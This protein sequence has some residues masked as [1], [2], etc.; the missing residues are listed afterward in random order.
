MDFDLYFYTLGI[1][2]LNFL[3]IVGLELYVNSK[4]IIPLY[5]PYLVINII[6]F[7][8]PKNPKFV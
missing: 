2:E 5:F 4:F 7:D 8:V 6:C 1:F 3:F